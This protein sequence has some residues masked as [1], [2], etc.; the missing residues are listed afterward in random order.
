MY[1]VPAQYAN[2]NNFIFSNVGIPLAVD[3]LLAAFSYSEKQSAASFIDRLP[4][5]WK[6]QIIEH[7]KSA[8]ENTSYTW[9][10]Y[11]DCPFVNKKLL[12]DWMSI[13]SVD[14]TGRYRMIYKLMI[15]IAGQAITKGYPLTAEQL[16][17][18]IKELDADTSRKYQNRALDIEAN[19][20][21]EYAYK[22]SG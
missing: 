6:E 3:Y 14:G 9:T 21:L 1:Y 15:S 18:L 10:S 8:L 2:A 20:A 16:V 22:Y 4:D 17:Q 12:K 13:A 11:R 19:N 5:A 7:R